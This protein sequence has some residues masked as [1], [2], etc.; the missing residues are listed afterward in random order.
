M[1]QKSPHNV[2]FVF[3]RSFFIVFSS[4]ITTNQ[5][6]TVLPCY[7]SVFFKCSILGKWRNKKV[8]ESGFSLSF[9]PTHASW[10][11][12]KSPFADISATDTCTHT[13]FDTWLENILGDVVYPS[14]LTWFQSGG[15][16]ELFPSCAVHISKKMRLE[17]CARRMLHILNYTG[18]WWSRVFMHVLRFGLMTRPI[19]AL[20]N[21]MTYSS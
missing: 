11:G 19:S 4:A 16:A 20:Y 5:S 15:G 12:D 8:L 6:K 3:C 1:F 18:V 7:L 17:S 10:V 13:F 14:C 2:L 9:S 21:S